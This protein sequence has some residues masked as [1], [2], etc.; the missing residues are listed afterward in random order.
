MTERTRAEE[1]L[2]QSE[3]RFR[4]L[5]DAMPLL[6]W[7]CDQQGKC[8]YFN[9]GWLQFTGRTL[10]QEYG[11]GWAEGVHPEDTARVTQTFLSA[12]SQREGFQMEY[13]LRHHTGE[14][15]W[16]LDRGVPWLDADGQFLGYIGGC[17]DITN[18]KQT[19]GALRES[20]AKY[21]TLFQ[22]MAEEVHF[23]KL[24]RDATGRIKTWRVVEINP[25]TEKTWGRTL[26]QVTGKT[27]DEIFGAGSTDHFMPVIQKIMAEGVP[28]QFEDYFPPLDKCFRFT[29]VPLGEY[30]ITTGADI[31]ER[32]RADEALGQSEQRLTMA[33]EAANLGIFDGDI[34]S[35]TLRW[36]HRLREFWGLGPDEPVTV[37]TFFAGVHPDD[38]AA[39][40]AAHDQAM[41]PAGDGRY[42]AEHRIVTADGRERWHAGTGQVSFDRGKPVRIVGTVQDIT[43]RKR[44]EETVRQ[45]ERFIKSVADASPHWLYVFDFDTMG[46][47][48]ANRPILHG[49]GYAQSDLPAASQLETF[50]A[51]MPPEELPHLA[52]LL[53]EWRAM[54]DGVVRDDEYFLRHADGT[55]HLFDGRELVFARRADGSVR[56]VLGL[57]LDITARKQA[58]HALE[59]V[60]AELQRILDTAATGLVHCSADLRYVSVNRAY[61]QW[62]G[63]GIEQIVGRPMVDGLGHTAFEV[64]RPYVERV[65]QGERVEFE[66]ELPLQNGLKYIQAVFAPDRNSCGHIVGWVASV[67]DISRRRRAEQELLAAKAKAEEAQLAAEAASR[68]KDHFVAVLSHEL[69]NPLTPVLLAL[70]AM[71][72]LM[73]KEGEEVLE[74]ARRN[75]ELEA[76]LIDDLLDVTRI[77]RGKVEL[78]R[79]VVELATIL[80]HAAEVCRADIEGRRLRF[81]ITIEDGSHPVYADAARL[82]QVFWN[83]IKNAVKFTPNGGCVSVRCRRDGG[84]AIVQVADSGEGIAAEALPRLFDAFEQE[85]RA[86]TRQFG[87]LGLGLAISKAL[88]ELHGGTIRVHSAGKGQGATF[89]VKLPVANP[90]ETRKLITPSA[91]TEPPIAARKLRILIAEDHGDTAKILRQLLIAEGHQVKA[92]GDVATALELARHEEF[93]VLVSDIALPDGSGLELMRELRNLQRRPAGIALSG[94][95]MAD[96]LRKSR[97]AGFQEHLTKPVNFDVLLAAIGRVAYPACV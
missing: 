84:H 50:R 40:K 2:R 59:A 63:R 31:T 55:I 90:Q 23:W 27:P 22:H 81:G 61:A 47:A 76:R 65:L 78:D 35:G 79:K 56:Q 25:A 21:R 87:G 95:G 68:A 12:L 48:Y 3:R 97:D 72:K 8:D 33:K 94:F 34:A 15:R 5:S 53:D 36:D 37:D 4:S 75:V 30:F 71:E 38:W 54:P 7:Q 45:N 11:D 32:K 46:L 44:A 62:L 24:V 93:D 66:T 64:I 6:V 69:R 10:E 18:R 77:V 16:I 42:F 91:I 26:E 1:A 51:Y 28:H 52:R 9:K 13:R 80:H 19:E 49:L 67:T 74:I 88:V 85:S 92:A 29:V 43:D 89:T 20:E 58:E 73:P 57:L 17:L 41:D 83:L 82:Q 96:D 70:A 14:H 60:S 39:V 86:T